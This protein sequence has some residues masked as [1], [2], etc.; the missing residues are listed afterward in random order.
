LPFL[1]K[2]GKFWGLINPVDLV[3]VLVVLGLVAGAGYKFLSHRATAPVRTARFEFVAEAIEPQVAALVHVG[4]AVSSPAGPSAVATIGIY[5]QPAK[6]VQVEVRPA[7]V[8]VTTPR[9][10]R[11][12]NPD[13]YLKDVI[14][15]AQ[16]STPVTGGSIDL[17]G[18]QLRAGTKFTLTSQL[19][20]LVGTV[21]QVQVN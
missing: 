16:G 15:W 18:E 9:G 8:R 1:D 11:A 2:K 3:I 12:R 20:S 6:I 5:A 14:I 17:A 13:P 10:T 21:L 7:E 4:D 19:Y